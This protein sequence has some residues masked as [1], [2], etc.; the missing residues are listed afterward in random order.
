MIFG[1]YI[2]LSFLF[3]I[4]ATNKLPGNN[5]TMIESLKVWRFDRY[6]LHSRQHKVRF[7]KITD[8]L[9]FSIPRTTHLYFHSSESLFAKWNPA[10][11]KLKTVRFFATNSHSRPQDSEDNEK[12][13]TVALYQLPSSI[14]NIKSAAAFLRKWADDAAKEGTSFQV[15][16]RLLIH[17]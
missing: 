1:S 6:P 17:F 12:I 7:Q 5:F 2:S 11:R 9:Y 8:P 16:V 15:K 3:I 4:F 14:F 10:V 13:P